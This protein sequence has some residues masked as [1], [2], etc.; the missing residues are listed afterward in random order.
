MGSITGTEIADR[1]RVVL[2][3]TTSGG[4][5]WLDAELLDWINDSQREIVLVKP[6][7]SSVITNITCVTGTKQNIPSDG[8]RLLSV[9]RNV[10]GKSVRLVNRAI[11]DSEN[12]DWHN[13]TASATTDH[14]IYDEDAPTVFYVYPPQPASG[15]GDL[16]INYSQSPTDLSVLGDTIYLPDI[17]ANAMLDYVLYRAY[18][19][20]TE[21]AGNQNRAATHYNMFATSLGIKTQGEV[22]ASPHSD[23]FYGRGA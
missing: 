21:Y 7:A 3:D 8:I 19:K 9:I 23:R 15:Q 5:R 20:D 6:E 18:S 17:Y 1:A 14:F 2:Q 10:G 11:M 22:T 12:P 16:E 13:V 4:V